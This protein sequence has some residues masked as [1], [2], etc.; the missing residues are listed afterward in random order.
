M[1]KIRSGTDRQTDRGDDKDRKWDRQTPNTNLTRTR[2]NNSQN[3]VLRNILLERISYFQA[4]TLALVRQQNKAKTGGGGGGVEGGEG[5][6][7]CTRLMRNIIIRVSICKV[8]PWSRFFV[9]DNVY[10]GI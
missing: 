2:D 6:K 8:S 9:A 5:K 1:T 10:D 7:R 4:A 3:A